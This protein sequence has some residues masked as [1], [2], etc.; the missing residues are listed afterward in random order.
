[1]KKQKG[2]SRR[3]RR[4]RNVTTRIEGRYA[5]QALHLLREHNVTVCHWRS[6]MTGIAWL[7]HPDRV[8]EAPHPKS[9]MSFAVLAHE[10][11]H[12]A[13][14]RMRPRWHE[15]QQAWLFAFNAMEAHDIPLTD[16]VVERYH[17]AMRYAL[18]KALRRGLKEIPAAMV[19]F[20]TD[21]ERARFGIARPHDFMRH[22]PE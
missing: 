4:Q 13:L 8:I 16:N 12:H 3:E 15:E 18:A 14:G 22:I 6:S 7:G 1:M 2:A 11:G 21:E 20:L 19:E 9:P 5:A 10:V 17:G